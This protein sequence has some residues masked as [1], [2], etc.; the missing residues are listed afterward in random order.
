L[1]K[2]QESAIDVSGALIVETTRGGR[3]KLDAAKNFYE[4]L[5]GNISSSDSISLTIRV[6]AEA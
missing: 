4:T 5:Y 6:N 1:Q 3:R 2:L